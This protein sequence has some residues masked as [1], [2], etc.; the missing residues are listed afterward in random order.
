MQLQITLLMMHINTHFQLILLIV[1][2][3]SV[4]YT[5][6]SQFGQGTGPILMSNLQ[7]SGDESHL[8]NC[9]YSPF[10]YTSCSHYY[11]VGVI[12]EGTV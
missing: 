6:A 8:I 4:P 12:C 3:G 7:C 2:S 1:I 9:S 5:T 10:L 11:D